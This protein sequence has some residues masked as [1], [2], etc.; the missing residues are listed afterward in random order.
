[1]L[2][3]KGDAHGGDVV[4]CKMDAVEAVCHVYLGEVN[5][6]VPGVGLDD[7][8]EDALECL[9]ELHGLWRGQWERLIVDSEE[10]VVDDG[11]WATFTLWHHSDRTE[12]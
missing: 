3:W 7:G 10:G 5:G 8:L 12:T 6:P 11:P 1:M 2:E 4:W 9:T